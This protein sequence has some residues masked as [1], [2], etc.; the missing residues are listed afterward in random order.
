M[1]NLMLSSKVVFTPRTSEPTVTAQSAIWSHGSSRPT[2]YAAPVVT[3]TPTAATIPAAPMRARRTIA[4]TTSATATTSNAI[5][6]NWCS[7]RTHWSRL[8]T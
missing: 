7:V 3:R 5:A 1:M 8:G 2:T 4:I 6:A